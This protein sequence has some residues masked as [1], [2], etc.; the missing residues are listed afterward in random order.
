MIWRNIEFI[1][2]QIYV[3]LYDLAGFLTLSVDQAIINQN[4]KLVGSRFVVFYCGA[5]VGSGKTKE[6]NDQHSEIA[7]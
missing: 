1:F 7:G 2:R 5:Q 6:H 4:L 3:K